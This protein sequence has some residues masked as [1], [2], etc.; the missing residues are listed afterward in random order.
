MKK[1]LKITILALSTFLFMQ[2]SSDNDDNTEQEPTTVTD[3]SIVL[4][5]G[6][7]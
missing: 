5:A 3:T 1:L 7:R 6:I 4:G 2:W